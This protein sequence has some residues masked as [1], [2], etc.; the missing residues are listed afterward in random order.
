MTALKFLKCLKCLKY[1]WIVASLCLAS[2]MVVGLAAATAS[3]QQSAT[4]TNSDESRNTNTPN[5]P[6][7]ANATVAQ[8]TDENVV[9]IV[10]TADQGEIDAGKLAASKA[11]NKEVKD[12]AKMMVTEHKQNEKDSKSLAKKSKLKAKDNDISKGLKKSSKEAIASLKKLKGAD[13]DKAYITNQIAMHE[14]ILNDLDTKLIPA[15]KNPELKSHLEMTK[16]HVQSH[17]AKARD[18]EIIISK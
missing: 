14:Q 13:F 17:L 5:A 15:A 11:K 12:F 6:P 10:A 4:S 9:H 2:G 16:T 1:Q 3:A 18:L 7:V 8:L